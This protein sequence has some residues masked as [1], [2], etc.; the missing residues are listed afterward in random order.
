MSNVK[1]T[2]AENLDDP[3]Y[4]FLARKVKFVPGKKLV[5]GLT[6]M[7]IADV[8][9]PIG[10]PFA[11]FP[12]EKK[13]SVS[14]I[15]VPSFSESQERGYSLQGGGYYFA[16]SDYFDLA[17]TGDYFTNGSFSFRA[18]SDYRKRYKFS[19]RFSYCLLYT[20][21]SPRD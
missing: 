15:I 6:N 1:I 5:A 3:E 21:P 8:P 4:Y 11:F 7:Y 2:T 17:L 9:T 14:G 12:F 18:D 20:S 16:L 19:G 13:R 10:L